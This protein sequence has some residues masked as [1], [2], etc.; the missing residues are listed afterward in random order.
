LVGGGMTTT[1]LGVWQ[2]QATTY[3]W[4]Y[5]VLTAPVFHSSQTICIQF[6]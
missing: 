1:M 4:S 6:N 5:E 2:R 3:R